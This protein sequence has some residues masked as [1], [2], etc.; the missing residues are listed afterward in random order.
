M[1]PLRS[2]PAGHTTRKDAR[3]GA[4]ATGCGVSS[5]VALAAHHHHL[6]P[7]LRHPLPTPPVRQVK[8]SPSRE[9][10]MRIFFFQKSSPGPL[11]LF[12]KRRTVSDMKLKSST[13]M[14]TQAVAGRVLGVGRTR[15][16]QL[17]KEGKLSHVPGVEGTVLVDADSLRRYIKAR[18]PQSNP[19]HASG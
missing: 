7:Q 16:G 4:A 1:P 13:K 15:A 9:K 18:N 2:F 19:N 6:Q 12:P 5:S 14:V 17:L 11:T 10:W 3:G 8:V